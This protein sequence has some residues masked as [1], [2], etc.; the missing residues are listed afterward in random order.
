MNIAL[1][2]PPREKNCTGI[3]NLTK[4]TIIETLQIDCKNK[5]I[6][7]DD[8]Y[9]DTD[10]LPFSNIKWGDMIRNALDM[11]SCAIVRISIFYIHIG[12]RLNI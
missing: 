12:I 1:L 6:L 11:I 10:L 8:P 4:G 9:F 7:S 2:Y 3:R 5:Y